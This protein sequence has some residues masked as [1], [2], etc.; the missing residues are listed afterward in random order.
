MMNKLL[1]GLL[2]AGVIATGGYAAASGL[3]DTAPAR[4]VSLP[5]ATTN[6]GTTTGTTTTGTTT[7]G[8][9]TAG[10]TTAAATTDDIVVG[11][12]P[13]PGL[14]T[15]EDISGPC[16]EAEHAND[17]RCTG[18][19]GADGDGN[20]DDRSGSNRDSDDDSNDDDRSGPNSG[21]GSDDDNDNDN[22]DD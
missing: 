14:T 10:T 2:G 9:T 3:D 19:T 15:G 16:D 18:G 5:G 7:A 21:S 22:D 6:D 17:P 13:T 20:D 1:I 8:T 11:N 4:T 12:A